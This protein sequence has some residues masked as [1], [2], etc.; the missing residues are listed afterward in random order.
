MVFLGT[1][2]FCLGCIHLEFPEVELLGGVCAGCTLMYHQDCVANKGWTP[3][4]RIRI[5]LTKFGQ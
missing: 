4:T 1:I 5:M 3:Y 2:F